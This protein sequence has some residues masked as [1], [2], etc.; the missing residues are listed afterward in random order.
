MLKFYHYTSVSRLEELTE[1]YG[2]ISLRP[3]RRMIPLSINSSTIP[4]KAYDGA[5][6]GLLEPQPASWNKE[7]GQKSLLET[8]LGDI[9]T[10]RYKSVM[11]LA[12]ITVDSTA[13][14][15]YVADWGVHFDPD[16]DGF[17]SQRE[18]V[19]LRVKS[20]YASSLIPF[21]QYSDSL[22]YSAPE[23]I[24]FS[25]IPAERIKTIDIFD[26]HALTNHLR[27]QRGAEPA[28]EGWFRE[29]ASVKMETLNSFRIQYGL[30]PAD[31][32]QPPN[33]TAGIA[34][35]HNNM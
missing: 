35:S 33:K 16:Y 4:D 7:W 8:V 18:D 28:H 25:P 22:G 10:G 17:R 26:K 30:P 15:I 11:A 6:F 34:S 3:C 5:L 14:D 24:C 2:N 31:N 13:D 21:D 19:V 12:E 27:L 29:P 9:T 1:E 20:A 23:V 32:T